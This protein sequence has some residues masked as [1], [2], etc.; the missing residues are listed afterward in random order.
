MGSFNTAHPGPVIYLPEHKM[1]SGN[2]RV[3]FTAVFHVIILDI[4]E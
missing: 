2:D 1:S 4:L 3:V